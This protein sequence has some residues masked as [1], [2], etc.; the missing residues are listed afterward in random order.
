MS[1]WFK[2]IT[3]EDLY[4]RKDSIQNMTH[5]LGI[6]LTEIGDDYL[7]GTM[8]IDVRTHQPMGIMHGGASC[9][10]AETLGSFAAKYCVDTSKQHTVGQDIHTTHLRAKSSGIVT[11]IAKPVHLG[12]S[13]QIWSIDITDEYGKLISVT[14]LTMFVKDNN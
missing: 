6:E 11:G 13:T 1:I 2:P 12:R 14:R 4:T 8:P 10:L 9:V 3:L 7:K 5:A